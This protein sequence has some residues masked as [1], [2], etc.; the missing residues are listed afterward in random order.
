VIHVFLGN[1]LISSDTIVPLMM[2]VHRRAP[3]RPIH[4][5]CFHARTCR[6]LRA[7]T[8]LWDAIGAIGRFHCMAGEGL[9]AWRPLRRA[10][11]ALLLLRLTFR[12]LFGRDYFVH[13]KALNDGPLS[14][15]A[16]VH[17]R[18]TVFFE[19]NGW[20]Y[21]KL[22]MEKIAT[23][24]RARAISTRAGRGAV[25]VGFSADWP[26][27][28]HPDNRGKVHYRIAPSH[29][30]PAWLEFV[31]GN[32]QRFFS[33]AFA[34]AGLPESDAVIVYVLGWFGPM[35]FMRAPDSSER[36]LHRTL[37][38]L[39]EESDG[40]PVFVKPHF[41]SDLAVLERALAPFRN[42][43]IV[44]S[45]LHPAVLASRAA[46]FVCNYYSTTLGDA[47]LMGAPTIEF[48]DYSDKALAATGG[49]SMRGEH[50]SHFINGDEAR[51]RRVFNDLARRRT[52]SAAPAH[53]GNAAN[54]VVELLSG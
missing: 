50:V 33:R 6:M 9:G 38:V 5:Y 40:L 47:A 45:W 18:R 42:R 25:I 35:D 10:R 13:F 32:A 4:F 54:P 48:T 51:F 29:Q 30:S 7:N 34:E 1:K 8:V 49:G 28:R 37:R 39:A 11:I 12:A 46:A 2:E 15:L 21:D 19:T 22:M 53:R 3:S 36:L 16:R 26:E 44:V 14:L 17:P 41:I 20:G 24:G 23:I 52:T 43:P 31:T 27:F